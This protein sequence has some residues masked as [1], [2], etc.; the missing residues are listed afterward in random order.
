M[1][2]RLDG[3]VLVEVGIDGG[4]C[5]VFDVERRGKI[6]ESFSEINGVASLSKKR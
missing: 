4:D 2:V 1:F 6:G 5:G 3:P